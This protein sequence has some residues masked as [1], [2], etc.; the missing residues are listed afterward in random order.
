MDEKGNRWE[1]ADAGTGNDSD[2]SP[3]GGGHDSFVTKQS[4][5]LDG[6]AIPCRVLLN[7]KRTE[8]WS[9]SDPVSYWVARTKR[10][11]TVDTTVRVR[12]LKVLDLGTET[13]FRDGRVEREGGLT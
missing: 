5:T 9:T 4:L 10:W 12:V 1:D 8:P 3:V 2:T 13:H 11:Q 7:V 6:R